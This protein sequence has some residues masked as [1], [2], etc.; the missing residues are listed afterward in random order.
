MNSVGNSRRLAL[1]FAFALAACPADEVPGDLD[2]ADVADATTTDTAVAPDAR[3]AVAPDADSA[4][5]TDAAVADTA[6]ADVPL[7]TTAERAH[8]AIPWALH[9]TAGSNGVLTATTLALADGGLLVGATFADTVT[10]GEHTITASDAI[11]RHQLAVRV[12]PD[13]D[14]RFARHLCDGCLGLAAAEAPDGR[15][16]V[17]RVGTTLVA[18]PDDPD[19]ASV[20]DASTDEPACAITLVDPDSGAVTAARSFGACMGEIR[21]LTPLPDG[22]WLLGGHLTAAAFEDGTAF[23]VPDTIFYP[24]QAFIARLG[25]DLTLAW[26][27]RVGGAAA[28][29][30]SMLAP[31]GDTGFV[32]VGDFGGWPR[33]VTADFGADPPTAL[34]AV[35]SDDDPAYDLFVARYNGP[36]DLAFARR[37][38]HYGWERQPSWL[39]ASPADGVAFR[40][41]LVDTF[42]LRD[43]DP[44]FGYGGQDSARLRF[45]LDGAL[46]GVE[47]LPP[48]AVRWPGAAAWATSRQTAAGTTT[49]GEGPDALTFDTPAEA[50]G[51]ATHG[52]LLAHWRDDGALARAGLLRVERA[53][54]QFDVVAPHGVAPQPDGSWLIYLSAAADLTLRPDV[55]DA[56]PLARSGYERV[57]FLRAELVAR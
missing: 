44:D 14:V 19:G 47:P 43:G 9:S 46:L 49:V 7:P 26:V 39:T 37:V 15:I 52:L 18:N 2:T 33:H 11:Y 4:D 1:A 5:A 53:A 40:M 54:D 16:A 45:A 50:D 36:D 24:G 32:T 28:S 57:I 35:S 51:V 30:V 22:G 13:G 21:A 23:T 42:E 6:L 3:D 25:P 56:T 17:A 41:D 12:D 29:S 8:V 48:G 20:I 27:E 10:L 34:V 38:V 31:L 55:G